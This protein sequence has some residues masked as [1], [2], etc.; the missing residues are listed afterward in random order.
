MTLD[1]LDRQAC[2]LQ[3]FGATLDLVVGKRG[4]K[5]KASLEPYALGRVHQ[6]AF[7]VEAGIDTAVLPVEAM[8]QPEGQYIVR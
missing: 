6:L 1:E 5:G 7:S 3:P 8:L 4:H 2:C